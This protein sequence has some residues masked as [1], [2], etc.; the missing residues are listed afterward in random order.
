LSGKNSGMALAVAGVLAIGA[1]ASGAAAAT[2]SSNHCPRQFKGLPR[3]AIMAQ[4]RQA[5]ITDPGSG[6]MP[7]CV[8]AT[9]KHGLI[10]GPDGRPYGSLR[11]RPSHVRVWKTWY[12][13]VGIR[14]RY[15]PSLQPS[16]Q[17]FVV[18][19]SL[20]LKGD[21]GFVLANAAMNPVLGSGEFK[22][23]QWVP[24]SS[25]A[26]KENCHVTLPTKPYAKRPLRVVC[27]PQS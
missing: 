20:T 6:T 9:G 27:V 17:R 18:L 11:E 10:P 14:F 24:G 21:L 13:Y 16:H 22:W 1:A 8:K 25:P 4:D 26:A 5:I 15:M 2:S 3:W 23:T 7:Y 19:G 12:A